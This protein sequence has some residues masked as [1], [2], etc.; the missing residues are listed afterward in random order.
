MDNDGNMA[1][2]GKRVLVV[3][4]DESIRALLVRILQ[5]LCEVVPVAGGQDALDE[6]R[7]RRPDLVV[8]DLRMPGMDGWEVIERLERGGETVSIILLSG[9]EQRP[10]PESPLVKARLVKWDVF[11]T[12]PDACERLFEQ[13]P[14]PVQ[15][16]PAP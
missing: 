16:P 4:D 6:I 8:L 5:P 3:D 2:H 14:H 15:P 11:R 12:L 7:R 9:E 13:A 1:T 10:W